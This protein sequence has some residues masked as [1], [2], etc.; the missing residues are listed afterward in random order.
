MRLTPWLVLLSVVL[1]VSGVGMVHAG[2]NVWT[3]L[4]QGSVASLVIAPTAPTTLYAGS[5]AG[6]LRSTNG[7]TTWSVVISVAG[8]AL[9]IDPIT[10]TTVYANAFGSGVFKST[11]GGTTWSGVNT[12]LPGVPVLALAINPLTPTTLY[13]GTNGSGVFKSTDGGSSWSAMNTGLPDGFPIVS[14]LAID[15]ITPTTVYAGAGSAFK[16][17]DG[18]STWNAV[19]AD[20][21]DG[22]GIRF[23]VVD[24]L[25]PTTVYAADFQNVFRSTN[26]GSTWSTINL[27]LPT[28][29]IFFLAVDATPSTTLYVGLE[30]NGVFA[31]TFL[32]SCMWGLFID[33]H[34]SGGAWESRLFLS[35]IDTQQ[36]HTY[37]VFVLATDTVHPKKLS[38]GPSGIRQLTCD[39]VQACD[40]A[41]WVYVQSDAPVFGATLF[42]INTV[43]G[44]GAFTAQTPVCTFGVP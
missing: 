41:G 23:L 38:L 24:P 34:H 40:T 6:V 14:V 15:P 1:W 25:T 39:D 26:G 11:D 36:A 18:G 21:A 44:G 31:I 12:G 16:S 28:A 29:D 9:A 13:A 22:G 17:T 20:V 33:D 19:L 42:V 7:G 37:E 35:N 8:P 10:P 5:T 27:G 32:S 4:G 30:D 2:N 43:F 3:S